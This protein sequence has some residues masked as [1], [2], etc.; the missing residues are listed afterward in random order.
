MESINTELL[1]EIYNLAQCISIVLKISK[2][3]KNNVACFAGNVNMM[4]EYVRGLYG[5]A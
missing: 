1:D 2:T 4:F 3:S 5:Y